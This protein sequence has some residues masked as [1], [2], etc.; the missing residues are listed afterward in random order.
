MPRPENELRTVRF[1][2]LQRSDSAQRSLFRDALLDIAMS[3]TVALGEMSLLLE[4]LE[5]DRGTGSPDWR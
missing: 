5:D 3:Q 1:G 4:T 2:D